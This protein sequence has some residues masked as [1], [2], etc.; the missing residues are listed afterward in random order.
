MHATEISLLAFAAVF[1]GALL[2]VFLRSVLPQ[3]H[4][5]SDTKD[6]VKLGMGLVGTM[7]ALALGLLV[8][9]AKGYYDAQ[10]TELT[11]LSAN[12]VL[13]DRLLAHYGPETKETRELLRGAVGRIA[14]SMW[15]HNPAH[16]GELGPSSAGA[17]I[18]HDKIRELMPTNDAQRVVQ[19]QALGI[20]I[21]LAQTRWL[22]FA[23]SS[24]AVSIPLL[25]VLVAWLT[26]I[27]ISFGVFAPPNGTA[28]ISLCAAALSV[29]S[30]VFLILEMYSPY[31]GVIELSDAPLRIALAQLGQ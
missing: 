25:V 5:T 26:I 13:L 8:A 4:L 18:I 11:Q 23:Q 17:E 9:S 20:A 1:G 3:H 12:V 10:S 15:A 29:S 27:F 28:I 14:E 6:A 2:G 16:S 19:S 30:A 31:S 22:M 7:A 21:T 24:I